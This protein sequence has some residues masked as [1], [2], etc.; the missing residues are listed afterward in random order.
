M[1]EGLATERGRPRSDSA[2]SLSGG[3]AQAQAQAQHVSLPTAGSNNTIQEDLKRGES[4]ILVAVRLRPL[5]TQEIS[6]G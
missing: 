1:M 4:N 2:V 6:E 3:A 5:S